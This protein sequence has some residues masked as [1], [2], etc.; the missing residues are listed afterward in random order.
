MT[1]IRPNNGSSSSSRTF[2]VVASLIISTG[3]MLTHQNKS[4]S[5]LWHVVVVGHS[6]FFLHL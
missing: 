6:G 2:I 3:L 1:L 5:E 4:R